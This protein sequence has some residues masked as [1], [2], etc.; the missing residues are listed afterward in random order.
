MKK[1]ILIAA[2]LGI[3]L[4]SNAFAIST[5]ANFGAQIIGAE[6]GSMTAGVQS[7]AIDMLSVDYFV[8]SY[9]GSIA[10]TGEVV[11]YPRPG[12]TGAIWDYQSSLT[13]ATGSWTSFG[14]LFTTE[15]ES[16]NGSGGPILVQARY[17]RIY[18]RLGAVNEGLED[19]F[20]SGTST[21][22][23]AAQQA[24]PEPA[25]MLLLGLGLVGLA[26]ARKKFKK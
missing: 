6:G 10:T 12:F 13:G 2:V 7:A 22:T 24:V 16:T 11:A 19:G 18:G 1:L 25:S 15:T 4:S 23:V 5:T 26:G 3:M 8:A 17:F 20:V 9:T 21:L 14:Q